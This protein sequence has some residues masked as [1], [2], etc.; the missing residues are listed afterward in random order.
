MLE[1]LGDDLWD[2]LKKETVI[3][4]VGSD[5]ERYVTSEGEGTRRIRVAGGHEGA[6]GKSSTFSPRDGRDVGRG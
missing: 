5:P 1:E 3:E 4:K 2:A 6:G